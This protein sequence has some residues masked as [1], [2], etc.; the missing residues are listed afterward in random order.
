MINDTEY[1]CIFF[2]FLKPF[3]FST[4][5]IAAILL[6]YKNLKYSGKYYRFN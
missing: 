4:K 1:K 2:S 3:H 6:D 5:Y